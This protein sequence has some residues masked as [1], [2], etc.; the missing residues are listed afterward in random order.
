MLWVKKS[1]KKHLIV[2]TR[3]NGGG[4][5]VDDITT[6]LS[7]KKYMEFKSEGKIVGTESQRRWT[8]PSI[9]LVGESNYSDAHCTPAGYKDL[10][11]GKLV[12][13][14][15]PGTCSFVWW[16]RIQNG[17][18][19]GIPNMQVTDIVGDVLENKQLE[20]DIKVKNSFE[21]ITNG[22]DEQ[23]EAAVTELLK[24]IN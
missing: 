17:I 1:I 14:P 7:G 22:K 6:F 18:V 9:M 19:F 12:G 8:K 23:I 21:A 13:M 4:D 11:I 16:E 24:Q 5:L 20:P 3:F 15:V 10:K 2:D